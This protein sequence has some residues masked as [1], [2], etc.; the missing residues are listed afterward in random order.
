MGYYYVIIS[1]N[2]NRKENMST[3]KQYFVIEKAVWNFNKNEPR[4]SIMKDK[5]F[6]LEEASKMLIAYEQLNDQEEK[7]YHLQL[8]DLLLGEQPLVLSD[9]VKK[10]NGASENSLF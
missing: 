9:E 6:S 1:H 3:Q 5:S 10:E 8:V 2:I 7:T 4:Y